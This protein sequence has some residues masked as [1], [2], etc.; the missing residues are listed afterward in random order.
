ML[1][2]VSG[3]GANSGVYK[4]NII[5]GLN[6]TKDETLELT[7]QPGFLLAASGSS[8]G[9]TIVRMAAVA[10]FDATNWFTPHVVELRADPWFTGLPGNENV[11]VFPVTQHLLSRMHGP[12]SVEGGETG[13]DRS[14]KSGVKLPGEADA[15]LFSIATQPPENEQ[16]D[17]LNIFDDSSLEDGVGTLTTDA[18]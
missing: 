8:T 9:V 15:P 12:I 16:I 14:L 1:I 17:V 6:A 10:T 5:R 18:R 7:K 3:A 11:K 4:I 13:A 2:Q